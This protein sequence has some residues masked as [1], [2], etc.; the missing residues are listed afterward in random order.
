MAKILTNEDWARER[1]SWKWR[2]KTTGERHDHLDMI[3]IANEFLDAINGSGTKFSSIQRIAR[4]A[5][6]YGSPFV[7]DLNRIVYDS[8][9]NKLRDEPFHKGGIRENL[10]EDE[11]FGREDA[12]LSAFGYADD[13]AFY[14]D[15]SSAEHEARISDGLATS[16]FKKFGPEGTHAHTT[17]IGDYAM[18]VA[19]TEE[20][21]KSYH[22]PSRDAHGRPMQNLDFYPVESEDAG[23]SGHKKQE[24]PRVVTHDKYG[25][26]NT[27]HE[28]PA[29]IKTTSPDYPVRPKDLNDP[30]GDSVPLEREKEYPEL[31][32]TYNEMAVQG[33]KLD[34]NT[35]ELVKKPGQKDPLVIIGPSGGHS[36]QPEKPPTPAPKPK[37]E[38]EQKAEAEAAKAAEQKKTLEKPASHWGKYQAEADL[39]KN[40]RNS[41]DAMSDTKPRLNASG[42]TMAD[43]ATGNLKAAADWR[44][45]KLLEQMRNDDRKS[46]R[47]KEIEEIKAHRKKF[48]L[49]NP[50]PEGEET[51]KEGTTRGHGFEHTPPAL[52]EGQVPAAGSSM[53]PEGHAQTPEDAGMKRVPPPPAATMSEPAPIPDGPDVGEF[54]SRPWQPRTPVEYPEHFVGGTPGQDAV[55]DIAN[56]F[57]AQNPP[58]TQPAP[59]PKLSGGEV[60]EGP[61]DLSLPGN[62]I[63]LKDAER[64]VAQNQNPTRLPGHHNTP[65]WALPPRIGTNA[66]LI[67]DLRPDERPDQEPL[68][69]VDVS[70]PA[71]AQTPQSLEPYDH[72]KFVE[73]E[74]EDRRLGIGAYGDSEWAKQHRRDHP[75]RFPQGWET[76]SDDQLRKLHMGTEG[77]DAPAPAPT[78]QPPPTAAEKYPNRFSMGYK[79]RDPAVSQ[80]RPQ[81][82]PDYSG[83]TVHTG[84][85]KVMSRAEYEKNRKIP[86]YGKH[87]KIVGY[88]GGSREDYAD[89]IARKSSVNLD[90]P[91]VGSL[92]T[93]TPA[94]NRTNWEAKLRKGA[95][96]AQNFQANQADRFVNPFGENEH[97]KKINRFRASRGEGPITL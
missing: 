86:I 39:I 8:P 65:G 47:E 42:G 14:E 27:G 19:Y 17:D 49:D 97:L 77:A 30:A 28:E 70:F 37:P 35:G 76:M 54:Q 23:P 21:T 10:I 64:A 9:K 5:Q 32:K 73:Q 40:M 26:P 31:V 38:A 89:T 6:F 53:P 58:T 50:A 34:P 67:T 16:N 87:G 81:P 88:K 61:P 45:T 75:E 90:R 4:M 12:V 20:N 3:K 33:P 51:V 93:R 24:S 15:E 85:G 94:E 52:E 48:G 78:P 18:P 91:E 36:Q 82:A 7:N 2:N 71:P 69:R 55:V 62:P 22:R 43:R 68:G 60:V 41:A 92:N 80:Y 84:D 44:Q 74:L 79:Y 56:N 59:I 46:A 83:Q 96:L 13:S 57:G 63:P 72:E 25:R 66:D 1:A 29:Q 95:E 11:S